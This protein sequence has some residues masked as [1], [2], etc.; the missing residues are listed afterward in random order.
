MN[1]RVRRNAAARLILIM[2]AAYLLPFIALTHAQAAAVA[3]ANSPYTCNGTGGGTFRAYGGQ[4]TQSGQSY[5]GIKGNFAVGGTTLTDP[6]Y[7]GFANWLGL[8]DLSP[9]YGGLSIEWAQGGVA[10]GFWNGNSSAW[11]WYSETN[12]YCQGHVWTSA[13]S[14]TNGNTYQLEMENINSGATYD[15]GTGGA[16]YFNA[17]TVYLAGSSSQTAYFSRTGSVFRVDANVEFYPGTYYEPLG[18][19]SCFGGYSPSGGCLYQSGYEL[20]REDSGGWSDWSTTNTNSEDGQGYH[21]AV[22]SGHANNVIRVY[23]D[24]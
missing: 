7:D 20:Q 17:T 12:T 23:G 24:Y 11:G 22:I 4:Y 19:N 10:N 18:G 16:H 6:T 1:L 9:S 15:C 13:G 5:R 3:C 14:Y 21:H 2:T 8:D